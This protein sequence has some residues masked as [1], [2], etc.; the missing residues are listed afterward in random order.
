M[1]A[2]AKATNNIPFSDFMQ[3][4]QDAADTQ[5]EQSEQSEQAQEPAP[6]AV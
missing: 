1:L 5:G 6:E 2:I 3:Q 4:R